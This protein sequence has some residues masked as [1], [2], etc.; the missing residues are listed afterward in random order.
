M[1]NINLFVP[2]FCNDDIFELQSEFL[3]KGSA[4]LGQKNDDN[5]LFVK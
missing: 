5:L 3:D 2:K 1:K 4:G